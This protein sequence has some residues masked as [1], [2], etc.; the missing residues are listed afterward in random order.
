[1]KTREEVERDAKEV[2]ERVE[3]E[4]VADGP[5]GISDENLARFFRERPRQLERILKVIE[6]V[7]EKEDSAI[8]RTGETVSEMG[9]PKQLATAETDVLAAAKRL[10]DAN[11][12]AIAGKEPPHDFH[13][14]LECN[15]GWLEIGK[16]ALAMAAEAEARG[17]REAFEATVLFAANRRK[18]RWSNVG[19][20][21]VYSEVEN[22]AE[23]QRD[24]CGPG[25]NA[26]LPSREPNVLEFA[27]AEAVP[28]RGEEDVA[29]NQVDF[30]R[31]DGKV[32]G[33]LVSNKDGREIPPHEY[34]VFRPHDDAF[35]E[36]LPY[37]RDLLEQKKASTEQLAAVD[38]LM[39][40]VRFWRE[41]HPERCKVPDVEPGEISTS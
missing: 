29:P 22:W 3:R 15:P 2:E 10:H 37:Y 20:V 36:T 6:G 40:R 1:M 17:R 30:L 19:M 21:L 5:H 27:A 13:V 31:L 28:P 39:S 24:A 33:T 34:V 35:V 11:E 4:G 14:S 9:I 23:Q 25:A 38:D 8:E 26:P 16:E 7:L 32:H 41:A 12:R 18:A